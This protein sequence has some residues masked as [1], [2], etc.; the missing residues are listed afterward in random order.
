[1]MAGRR[2]HGGL[3][4]VIGHRGVAGLAPEN[5]LAGI[6]AAAALGLTWVELDIRLT[7]DRQPVLLHDDTVDRTTD[8]HGRVSRL[9]LAAIRRLDAGGWFGSDFSGEPPPTLAEAIAV[10][11]RFRMGA[12]FEI[13]GEGS[14]AAACARIAAPLIVRAW[15]AASPRPVVSSFDDRAVVAAMIAAP[16]LARALLVDRVPGDWRQR[17]RRC[18]AHALHVAADA[19]TPA[20]ARGLAAAGISVACY[21]VNDRR[22]AHRLWTMGVASVFSDRP[23]RLGA[24]AIGAGIK[25]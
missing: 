5:T 12:V 13:K 15:P 1:M 7:R 24:P 14:E 18:G 11:A 23:E 10:L 4:A 8:G 2:L 16:R 25:T 20:T 21:T 22:R 17:L 9:P 19:L 6:A 3:P